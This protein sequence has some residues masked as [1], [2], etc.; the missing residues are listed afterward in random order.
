MTEA[1]ELLISSF[2]HSNFEFVSSFDIRI[3]DL[4]PH[5]G[6]EEISTG[7]NHLDF[8]LVKSSDSVSP[9]EKG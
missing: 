7:T 2:E 5:W 9:H 8:R 1:E 6:M 4:N 3:S